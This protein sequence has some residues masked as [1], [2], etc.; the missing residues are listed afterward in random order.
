MARYSRKHTWFDDPGEHMVRRSGSTWFDGPGQH[1]VRRSGEHTRPACGGRRPAGLS[2]MHRNQLID[3][4]T[5]VKT[6]L[7]SSSNAPSHLPQTLHR[8]LKRAHRLHPLFTPKQKRRLQRRRFSSPSGFPPAALIVSKFSIRARP[9]RRCPPSSTL[10]I[11][12]PAAP[13]TDAPG[14]SNSS[15]RPVC[16]AAAMNRRTPSAAR[17]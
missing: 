17:T 9:E 4:V 11:L 3:E 1:M 6:D 12:A 7:L 2:S 5:P 16:D 10:P 15:S 13:A 14:G 8:Q